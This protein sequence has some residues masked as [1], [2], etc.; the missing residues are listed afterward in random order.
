MPPRVPRHRYD[1]PLDRVWIG[2][3]ARMGFTIRRTPDVYASTDG[4]RT[5]LIGDDDTLDPDDCLAQ[6]IFHELCHALAQG[7]ESIQ[8]V[9]WGLDNQT[10]RDDWRE[11]A[12]LRTQAALAD[13]HG[14]RR[15]LAPTT[16]Y[17]AWYDALPADPLTP[18][19]DRSVVAARLALR[20]AERAPWAPHLADALSTT[21]AIARAAAA[22]PD[23]PASIWSTVE[24]A[25]PAH[26]LG[27]PQARA[28][29][30]AA[31]ATCAT[32]AWR[33][34]ARGIERCRQAP[35]PRLD[36]G[37]PACE[38]WEPEPDCQ[39]CGAC[40]RGAYDSVTVA[41]RDPV[42]KA[43]PELI[44]VRETYVELRREGD[45][46][47]ALHGGRAP[48]ERYVCAI[49]DDR[50]RPCREFER[51]GGNCLE[52]RRRVGLSR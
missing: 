21:A 38:R 28:G 37:W 20:R 5:I 15:T 27:L 7:D 51:G 39:D 18:P 52:A 50:P 16:D 12:C 11:H 22:Y 44:V 45:R 41:R 43:H 17:R 33:H 23:D 8:R 30:D 36:P 35:G 10:D 42:V 47:A 2:A 14:L 31:A 40:C 32:C 19:G 26:P 48:G 25:S 49:Y 46:C 3:A 34:V 29:T 24:P 6:M 4:N 9:D 13:P 1:D